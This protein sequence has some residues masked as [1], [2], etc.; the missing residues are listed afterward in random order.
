M[1][2]GASHLSCRADDSSKAE[3]EQRRQLEAELR[4]LRQANGP[5]TVKANGVGT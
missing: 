2:S 1:I 3:Q 4:R 5:L